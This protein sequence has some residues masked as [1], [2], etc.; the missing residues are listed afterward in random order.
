MPLQW[1][2]ALTDAADLFGYWGLQ[3]GHLGFTPGDLFGVPGDGKAG[4]VAWAMQG[5]PAIAL[6][7]GM[8]Q[9]RNGRIWRS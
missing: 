3:L 4:G 8:A 2:F 5:N 1:Q 9:L 7:P 6:G